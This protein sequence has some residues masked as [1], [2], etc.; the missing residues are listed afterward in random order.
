MPHVFALILAVAMAVF[1]QVSPNA[2]RAEGR[3]VVLELFTSQGCSR[4]PPADALM[5]EMAEWPDVLPL[6]LHVDYWD[7][8]GWADAFALKANT[9]RQTAYA[10]RTE[11]RRLFTPLL[12]VGGGHMVEGYTPM[13]VVEHI[14]THRNMDTGVSLRVERR[15]AGFVIHG[16]AG[17]AFAYDATL[18]LVT[19]SPQER[20][21]IER[22]ENAGRT[23]VYTNVVTGWQDLGTWDGANPLVLE[24]G[25]PD[26]EAAVLV[27]QPEQ[28]VVLAAVRLR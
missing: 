11:R 24:Q 19:F 7:Y 28:G 4:C 27:Q 15:G 12:V 2:A 20:V 5:H 10:P 14:E 23:A 25:P 13:K 1:V 9:A 16:Q 6:S 21:V 26:Q 8:I 22:G 3:L 17:A 18:M